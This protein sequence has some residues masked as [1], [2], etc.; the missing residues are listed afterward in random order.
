V[1]WQERRLCG[2]FQQLTATH[3]NHAEW[4]LSHAQATVPLRALGDI[5]Y[6]MKFPMCIWYIRSVLTTPVVPLV[7]LLHVIL[8][9]YCLGRHHVRLHF[10]HSLYRLSKGRLAKDTTGLG[11]AGA[12]EGVVD[13]KGRGPEAMEPQAWV[14]SLLRDLTK[15]SE[16]VPGGGRGC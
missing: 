12:T 1:T 4:C 6:I 2:W 14:V 8:I 5:K 11:L 9:A 16:K 7:Y 15:A 13:H 10:Q 3:P